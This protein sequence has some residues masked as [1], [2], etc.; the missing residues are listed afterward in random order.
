MLSGPHN[1]FA[2][3]DLY[4]DRIEIKGYGRVQDMTIERND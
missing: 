4:K 3:A 2:V 1:A